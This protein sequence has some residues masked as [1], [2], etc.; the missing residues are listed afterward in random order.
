M[1]AASLLEHSASAQVLMSSGAYSQNFDTL[2][3]NG[4]ANSWTDNSTLPG[5]Y[6]S[7]TLQG[8]AITNYRASSGGE[9]TGAIYSFGSDASS[10]RALGSTASGTPG[11]FAYGMRFTND[12]ASVQTNFTISYTGEQWRNGGNTNAHKLAFSYRVSSNAITSSDAVNAHSWTLFAALDFATPTV[13]STASELDGNNATNRQVFSSVLLSNVAVQPGQEI[14]FRW[15]DTDDPSF[16]H[17]IALDNLTNSFQA[18]SNLLP[19]ITIQPQSQTVDEGTNV[20]F[21]VA[22]S[23][24]PPLS[25]QWQFNGTN[26][27]DVTSTV[28]ALTNVSAAHAGPYVVVVTNPAGSTNSQAATLTVNPRLPPTITSQPQNQIAIEGT[29]AV[30]TVVATGTPPLSYQW[31]FNGSNVAGATATL[32]TL[33]NVTLAQAGTYVVVVTN[34]AGST[35]SQPATLTVIPLTPT[36]SIVTYNLKGNG[37]ADWSTNAAQVQ[38]IARQLIYLNPDL[39]TFNEI[40]NGQHWQMTNWVTAF[41]PAYTI[42]VSHGTDGYIRNGIGSRFPITRWTNYLD[43]AS[44]TNFGYNGRFTRDLLEA[45]IAVPGLGQPLHVFTVH[46]KSGSSSDDAAKRAAEANAISNWFATGFLTTNA[47]HPY[48]LTGDLNESDTNKL[49]IQRLLSVPTGLQLTTPVNP[50]TNELTFSIQ[51]TALTKRFDY[52][53]PSASLFTN[54]ASSQVFLTDVLTNPPPP[55]PLLTND[56]KTASDHLP[57]MMVFRTPYQPPFRLTAITMS[58]QFL[59]LT[60]ESVNG[61]RYRVDAAS[62]LSTWTVLASNLIATGSNYTFRTNVS[63]KREFYRV[64]RTP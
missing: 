4:T 19:S 57:V 47:S 25:Y 41:F 60:W 35:N 23:G 10:E 18:F 61:Q 38:A 39:I 31:Q 48:V 58:N 46:L 12:T 55:P 33:T 13:G 7:K 14:F 62:N 53:L 36:F 54:I 2:A 3:T 30:F 6:A 56:S 42:V 43:G 11:N 27:V 51:A 49:S 8:G 29:N 26:L 9:N 64:S 32:L 34:P 50:Y 21:T 17:G 5:W 20:T 40:P 24:T 59:T 22:A 45:E 52:I 16:D 1:I 37:A 44:L 28:L 63:R 15:Y